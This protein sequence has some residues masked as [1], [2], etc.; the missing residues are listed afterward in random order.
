MT[1]GEVLGNTAA[2]RDSWETQIPSFCL[3][4]FEG[5]SINE[6]LPWNM[7]GSWK[8]RENELSLNMKLRCQRTELI[9][10]AVKVRRRNCVITYTSTLESC[11]INKRSWFAHLGAYFDLIDITETC[12]EDLIDWNIKI[13]GYNLFRDNQMWER[14]EKGGTICQGMCFLFGDVCT[15]ETYV[16]KY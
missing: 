8:E 4:S 6:V 5:Q 2:Q 12:W 9:K 10:I 16:L 13:N 11:I 7:K 14:K 15:R 3:I 1:R